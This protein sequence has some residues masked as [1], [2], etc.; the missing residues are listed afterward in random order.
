MPFW[1]TVKPLHVHFR[2]LLGCLNHVEIMFC[3]FK[4]YWSKW[5]EIIFASPASHCLVTYLK[6][7]QSVLTICFLPYSLN[8]TFHIQFSKVLNFENWPYFLFFLKIL[9]FYLALEALVTKSCGLFTLLG[10]FL[11]YW[12]NYF[13]H[14]FVSTCSVISNLSV[15]FMAKC[16]HASL[17]KIKDSY[18]QWTFFCMV[19]VK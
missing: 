16:F 8:I 3:D 17:L 1:R 15:Q 9:R 10:V 2:M 14:S 7:Q 6:I 11:C 12:T 13:C 18:T 5:S 19:I 4:S